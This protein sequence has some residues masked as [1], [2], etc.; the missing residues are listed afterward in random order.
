[1]LPDVGM[2][3]TYS[4]SANA[5]DLGFA[6]AVWTGK[7]NSRNCCIVVGGMAKCCHADVGM[8][9]INVFKVSEC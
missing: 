6:W 9:L 8:L 1:M 4:K 5:N 3:Q 7:L 2:V